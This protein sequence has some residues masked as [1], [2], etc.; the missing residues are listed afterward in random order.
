MKEDTIL[1]VLPWDVRSIIQKEKLEFEYL[2]E[3]RLREGKPL[4]FLYHDTEV[5][6]GAKARR[7]YLVT[8]DNIREMLEYISNY[9]LYACEQEMRQGFITIEGGHRVGLSGQAIMENGKVKN[10]KYISSVNIRVAHEMI[11]C[12]DAVFPYIVCNRVLCHTLIVSPPGC[13]KTTML[14]DLI[15]QI[16]EGNSWIPGLAVGVVDERSEIAACYQGI[17]QNDLGPRTDVLDNCPKAIGMQMVL[18]SMSPDIIAVDELGGKED[19]AAVAQAMKSGVTVLGT[20]HAG[21]VEEIFLREEACRKWGE[22]GKMRFVG[23]KRKTPNMAGN[24]SRKVTVY[25]GTG[26]VLWEN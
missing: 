1:K 15:R 18:R 26:R 2:Q 16:S 17:P 10:L 24:K 9:S 3:I 22:E 19:F 14:R 4:I 20:M 25:D 6:P 23:L 7:P 11:G 5:I 13:G 21:S 8:K 12:A